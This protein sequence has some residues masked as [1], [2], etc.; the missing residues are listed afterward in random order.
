MAFFHTQFY[1]NATIFQQHACS[2]CKTEVLNNMKVTCFHVSDQR[3]FFQHFAHL[4]HIPHKVIECRCTPQK[5][6]IQRGQVWHLNYSY[7]LQQANCVPKKCCCSGAREL[8]VLMF[9]S[10]VV[11]TECFNA[12]VES[13]VT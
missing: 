1:S 13:F 11:A 10:A 4:T 2:E 8:L 5:L 7:Q 6:H 12:V 9:S 3:C